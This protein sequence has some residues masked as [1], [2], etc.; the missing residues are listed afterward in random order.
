MTDEQKKLCQYLA[1]GLSTTE[2]AQRL[3]INP[4]TAESWVMKLKWH[5][6]CFNLVQLIHVLTHM[7]VVHYDPKALDK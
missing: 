1:N 2:A 6:Q 4:R 7:G 5:Y 3:K